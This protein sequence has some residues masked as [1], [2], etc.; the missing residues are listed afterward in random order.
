VLTAKA[1]QSQ[2]YAYPY[3]YQETNSKKQSGKGRKCDLYRV[4]VS[5]RN[6]LFH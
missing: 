1:R 4:D 3:S 5:L 6:L 2:T